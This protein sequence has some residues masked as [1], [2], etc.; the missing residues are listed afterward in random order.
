MF[1]TESIGIFYHFI[2]STVYIDEIWE[3]KLQHLD[4]LRGRLLGSHVNFHVVDFRGH[5]EGNPCRK[6]SLWLS[7]L[8]GSSDFS[9]VSKVPQVKNRLFPT[10]HLPFCKPLRFAS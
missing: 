1:D 10:K 7:L 5:A 8:Q 2:C 6:D 4:V 9:L 3:S